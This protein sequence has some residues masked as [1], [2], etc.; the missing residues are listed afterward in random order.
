MEMIVATNA[1]GSMANIHWVQKLE[2]STLLIKYKDKAHM[3]F[4]DLDDRIRLEF[5]TQE[6]A[7]AAFEKIAE[8]CRQAASRPS[9]FPGLRA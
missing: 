7:D 3:S 8:H 1:I 6:E 2:K 9:A 5:E 4:L